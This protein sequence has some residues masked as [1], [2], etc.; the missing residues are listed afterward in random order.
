MNVIDLLTRL[1]GRINRKPYWIGSLLILGAAFAALVAVVA[2]WGDDALDGPYS[3]NSAM[4][5]A[6][7]WL[8]M[9]ASVPVAVKRLHDLNRSG[10]YLWPIFALEALLTAGD[11]SGVTGNE[12]DPN[13]L[14]WVLLGIYAMY[15]LVL[16]IVLG[17]HR[18]TPGRNDFGPDPLAPEEIPASVS[19]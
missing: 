9:L 16:F 19:L 8:I 17:F 14:G 15:A 11:L 3:G 13:A 10:R 18:G 4:S 5:L 1:D 2:I 12:T 6:I 7:G